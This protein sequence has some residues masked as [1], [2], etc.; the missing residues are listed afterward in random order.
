[1]II[2]KTFP[3]PY[4]NVN[5]HCLDG[6]EPLPSILSS[7]FG[8]AQD[9]QYVDAKKLFTPV[10]REEVGKNLANGTT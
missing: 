8:R 2:R 5:K 10:V 1:M 9:S 6:I 3:I 4:K 7:C